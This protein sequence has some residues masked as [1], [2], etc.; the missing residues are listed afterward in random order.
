MQLFCTDATFF[1]HENMK[2]TEL[3]KLLIIAFFPFTALYITQPVRTIF[4]FKSIWTR[5]QGSQILFFKNESV[6]FL[7]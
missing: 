6:E 5:S 2:K 1:A 3:K 7:R 4:L